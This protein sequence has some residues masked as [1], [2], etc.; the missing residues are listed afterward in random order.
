VGRPFLHRHA[1]P[2]LYLEVFTFSS[3]I[4]FLCQK[5]IILFYYSTY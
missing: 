1:T 3:I 5:S 4:L 2:P